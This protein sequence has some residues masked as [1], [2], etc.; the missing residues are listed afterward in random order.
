MAGYIMTMSE[1][2]LIEDCID[3]GIYS[4]FMELKKE[5]VWRIHHE[6]TFADFLSMK[7]GDNIYF[8]CERKIYGIGKLISINNVDSKF[9]NYPTAFEPNNSKYLDIKN[10]MLLNENEEN[11]SNRIVCFFKPSPFFFIEGIDMDDA[12]ASNP[13]KFK[14]LRALWKLSFIKVDDEEN[15]ALLDIIIKRNEKNLNPTE[16]SIFKTNF[17]QFHIDVSSKLN[18]KYYVDS[19]KL[20]SLC[21]NVDS[22]NHEMAIEAYIVEYLSKYKDSIF[23]EWDYISHQVIASPFKAIDY[24]DKMDVYGYKYIKDY[25]VIS[26]YLVIE[27]KK[28]KANIEVVDQTMKYVD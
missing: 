14:M 8:F 2:E 12:L 5:G 26:K 19:K 28:D 20:I 22:I 3:K 17:K 13:E 21:R 23:G 9:L 10:E 15:K 11:I 16:N 18:N 27:I 24:M 7:E 1:Y 6:G 25:N 4:T